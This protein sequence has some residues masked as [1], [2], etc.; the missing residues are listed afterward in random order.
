MNF[1]SENIQGASYV[2]VRLSEAVLS[3]RV[4]SQKFCLVIISRLLSKLHIIIKENFC[5]IKC[6]LKRVFNSQKSKFIW[7]SC[8]NC[9][10]WRTWYCINIRKFHIYSKSNSNCLWKFVNHVRISISMK[11]FLLGWLMIKNWFY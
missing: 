3:L 1:C 7:H 10:R 8:T 11:S 9:I 6:K 4:T 2:L 5:Q